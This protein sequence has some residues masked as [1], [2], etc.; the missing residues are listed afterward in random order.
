MLAV[1]INVLSP[2]HQSD[3]GN[4]RACKSQHLNFD[5]AVPLA[6]CWTLSSHTTSL[7]LYAFSHT[8]KKSYK[9]L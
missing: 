6:N 9:V 8:S 3:W 2:R 7:G 1:Y 5:Q 4:S